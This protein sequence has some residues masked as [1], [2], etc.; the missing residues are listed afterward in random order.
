MG[1]RPL[2]PDASN[3]MRGDGLTLHQRNFRLSM[4]ELFL[5]E[6]V[7]L[8]WHSCPE[9]SGVTVLGGVQEPWRCGTE[10]HGQWAWGVGW[11]W[12]WES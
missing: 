7:V 5:S 11:G 1:G 4:R 12:T 10:G 8:Q 9:S 2:L 6:R 3:G